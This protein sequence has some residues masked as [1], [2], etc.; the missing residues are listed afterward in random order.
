LE[1]K[2]GECS[3]V[4]VGV[5]RCEEKRVLGL[6]LDWG[7]HRCSAMD[8]EQ[9]GAEA[10]GGGGNGVLRKPTPSRPQPIGTTPVGEPAL[11][12]KPLESPM[13][14]MVSG[15]LADQEGGAE[16]NRSFSHLLAGAINSPT[17][18]SVDGSADGKTTSMESNTDGRSSSPG[19]AGGSFAERLAARGAAAIKDPGG[20]PR[21]PNSVRFKSLPPSRIPIPREAGY[22]TIPPGLSPTTLFDS[23]P[24]LLSTSQV[25]P[26][27]QIF[28]AN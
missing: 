7:A 27:C 20:P 10:G 18:D 21:P 13:S 5:S 2:R 1:G 28:P 16:E 8:G 9:A 19:P 22:L 6:G 4:G 26:P 17:S 25:H 15:F 14:A 12:F 23:S 3:W 24:L 11:G